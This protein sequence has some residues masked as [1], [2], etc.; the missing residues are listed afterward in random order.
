MHRL[1]CQIYTVSGGTVVVTA[2]MSAPVVTGALT[3]VEIP[4]KCNEIYTNRNNTVQ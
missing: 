3:A 1:Q 4:S 2:L